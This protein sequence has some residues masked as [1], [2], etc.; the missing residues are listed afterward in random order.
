MWYR[1]VCTKN[2]MRYRVVGFITRGT[3]SSKLNKDKSLREREGGREGGEDTYIVRYQK[4]HHRANY[5]ES[6]AD[7]HSDVP[8][9]EEGH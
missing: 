6:I 1:V 2:D 4:L 9:V 5:D 3:G 7:N 8:E